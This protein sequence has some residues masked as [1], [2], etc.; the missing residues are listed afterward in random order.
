MR[1][2]GWFVRA[3]AATALAAGLGTAAVPWQAVASQASSAGVSVVAPPD[4]VPRGVTCG[5][6]LRDATAALQSW[7]DSLARNDQTVQLGGG[8]Y[9]IE[10]TVRIEGRTNFVLDG[11]GATFRAYDDPSTRA[12]RSFVLLTGNTD[13]TVRDLTIEG[14]A[15]PGYVSS[16]AHQ[17]AFDVDW[18]G[19]GPGCAVRENEGVQLVDVTANRVKG[20]FVYIRG[21]N[22][23]EVSGARFGRDGN[24]STPDGNGRQGIAVVSGSNIRVLDS[25]IS[26]AARAVIDLETNLS[27]ES[28]TDVTI[29]NNTVR[30]TNPDLPGL[31]F[32]ANQGANSRIEHVNVLDNTLIGRRFWVMVT[33]P[34][35]VLDGLTDP[36]LYRRV[37]YRFVSNTSDTPAGSGSG[38]DAFAVHVN[39]V[40]QV[41]VWDN[42][43]VIGV[44]AFSS[45]PSALV[46]FNRS[47]STSV[48]FNKVISDQDGTWDYLARYSVGEVGYYLL[49]DWEQCTDSGCVV[50]EAGEDIS[51]KTYSSIPEADKPAV[52]A[53]P[54]D[55]HDVCERDNTMVA[56]SSTDG[57][58]AAIQTTGVRECTWR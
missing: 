8:C 7:L 43:V 31:T 19:V 56:Q 24:P 38:G 44:P 36:S 5:P 26:N 4:T 46:D 17:H 33:Q 28:I 30:Q 3:M 51:F 21:S 53:V 54:L 39:G 29:R 14:G 57:Q 6:G 40:R 22:D 20:D 2:N 25:E 41:L 32:F 18:C 10:G 23:V 45:W 13:V 34:N 12:E 37:D 11:Q 9:R 49:E 27:S 15:T 50:H 52:K 55:T 48:W 1:R 58:A 42:Q 47:Y 35:E 16:Q